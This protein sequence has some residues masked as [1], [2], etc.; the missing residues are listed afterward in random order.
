MELHC[1]SKLTTSNTQ[2]DKTF[3]VNAE[4]FRRK[5]NQQLQ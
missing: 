2:D 5:K 4:E 1:D 3:N